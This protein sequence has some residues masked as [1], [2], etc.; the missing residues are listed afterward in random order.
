[1]TIRLLPATLA[2]VLLSSSVPARPHA[3]DTQAMMKWAS[4]DVIKYRIVGVY[5]ARTDVVAG[6]D[7]GY[8][9]VTDRVVIDLRW[10][11]SEAKLSGTPTVANEPSAVKNLANP[12]PKCSPP[13]VDG[14]Y[15]HF[16]VTSIKEGLGG[17]LE[18]QVQQTYPDAK[19][20]Q[21]CTGTPKRV[22]GKTETRPEEL[23]IVSPMLFAMPETGSKD[24]TIS[25][26]KKSIIIKKGGWTW[27]YTPTV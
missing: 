11:Q 26:D 6:S 17:G 14:A 1:M 24:V 3:Q 23:M 2:L 25:P 4:V 15:E 27:T 19:V 7:V 20:I 13:T 18:M 21:S 9:D 22:P 8:A 16:T 5:S 12:E 10:K